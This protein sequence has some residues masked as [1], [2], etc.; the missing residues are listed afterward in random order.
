MEPEASRVARLLQ[1]PASVSPMP[2]PPP[3]YPES[4]ET[5][6]LWLRP[7]HPADAERM[8]EALAEAHDELR[9][10]MDWAQTVPDVEEEREILASRRSD[11]L[12]GREA[13]WLL[14]RKEDGVLVGSGG[15]P[16]PA[17]TRRR[18]EIGYWAR[19]S[20]VGNGYISE[21]TSH[22]A[23][24]CFERLAARRV[25][26]RTG[27]G[28]RRSRRVAELTGF[29]FERILVRDGC[30]P[31]GSSRDTAV[32]ALYSPPTAQAAE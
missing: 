28:N 31:D 27:A 32:Y 12:T 14:W 13:S 30:L 2:S 26:I 21:F 7:P 25:E 19:T 9:H 24:M 20:L 17:W 3:S 6:R 23:R 10:W 8:C 18:F 22:V 15:L 5:Q 11:H 4:L 29:R 16:R 1:S